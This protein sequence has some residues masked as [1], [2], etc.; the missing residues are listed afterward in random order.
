MNSFIY[1][2][3]CDDVL[4]YVGQTTRGSDEPEGYLK[5]GH[6]KTFRNVNRT[7]YRAKRDGRKLSWDILEECLTGQLDVFESFWICS[8]LS[9]GAKLSN[10]NLGGGG[11][12][13]MKLSPE[14][15]EKIARGNTGQVFSEERKRKIGEKSKGRKPSKETIALRNE[16]RA[17]RYPKKIQPLKHPIGRPK[18]PRITRNCDRCCCDIVL[19]YKDKRLK[20]EKIFCSFSCRYPRVSCHE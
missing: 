7:I 14:H 8:L 16:T 4:F 2:L 9:A 6:T 5:Y 10:M 12:R 20:Q 17:K 13:G 3:L 19:G 15:K 11:F 18:V 1:G